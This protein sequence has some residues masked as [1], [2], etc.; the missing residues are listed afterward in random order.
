M[1][2]SSIAYKIWKNLSSIVDNQ[3]GYIGKEK[4]A[5]WA[6]D[7][8]IADQ[9]SQVLRDQIASNERIASE[10]N[11]ATER[12]A[13]NTSIGAV[14]GAAMGANTTTETIKQLLPHERGAAVLSSIELAQKWETTREMKESGYSNVAI[15]Y[16]LNGKSHKALYGDNEY[17]TMMMKTQGR[18]DM[19][20]N[21]ST[22]GIQSPSNPMG[23]SMTADEYIEMHSLKD[24]EAMLK[25]DP[26]VERERQRAF[27]QWESQMRASG[28]GILVDIYKNPQ[29][30]GHGISA[31]KG[32]DAL[33]PPDVMELMKPIIGS[34][35]VKPGDTD[36]ASA[37]AAMGRGEENEHTAEVK[38][39]QEQGI[40]DKYGFPAMDKLM[41][42]IPPDLQKGVAFDPKR[43]LSNEEKAKLLDDYNKFSAMEIDPKLVKQ[44]Q[45]GMGVSEKVR[46][47]ADG[48]VAGKVVEGYM[49]SP[50]G[51]RIFMSMPNASLRDWTAKETQ[52]LSGLGPLFPGQ[53]AL[54][55]ED[56]QAGRMGDTRT[57]QL[58]Q[59]D[60]SGVKPK[61]TQGNPVGLISYS[62]PGTGTAM[63]PPTVT[64]GATAAPAP[65][66]GSNPAASAGGAPLAAGED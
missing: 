63:K 43:I 28:K 32:K 42:F 20:Q 14:L 41:S 59:A 33:I 5:K 53:L 47:N 6:H 56:E 62:S 31:M 22:F 19:I 58:K 13:R 4:K 65:A 36:W 50:T 16:A 2:L 49:T 40:I 55:T 21:I 27:D 52:M 3:H 64:Q 39:A 46:L 17:A 34:G 45:L 48:T 66:M 11:A 24:P 57:N 23:V 7:K 60:T 1:K 61:A 29:L 35:P 9:Q 18:Q 30:A 12:A 54:S 26:Q 51:E 15:E 38:W 44:R 10:T 8:A 37:L 25:V